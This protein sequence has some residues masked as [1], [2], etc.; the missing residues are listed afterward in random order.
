MQKRGYT[1]NKEVCKSKAVRNTSLEKHTLDTMRSLACLLSLGQVIT[2]L[3]WVVLPPK[4]F[5]K[6]FLES[7]ELST[8]NFEHTLPLGGLGD[9]AARTIYGD[10]GGRPGLYN[11]CDGPMPGS[12]TICLGNLGFP[13]IYVFVKVSGRIPCMLLEIWGRVIMSGLVTATPSA[14]SITPFAADLCQSGFSKNHVSFYNQNIQ[15]L[16]VHI[17]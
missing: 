8:R 13:H 1:K 17:P 4:G 3:G 15:L 14:P 11:E 5:L 10:A 9:S 2:P 12:C 7:H 16:M 6:F